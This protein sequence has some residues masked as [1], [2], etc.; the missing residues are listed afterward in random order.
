MNKVLYKNILL[1]ILVLSDF[2]AGAISYIFSFNIENYY[3]YESN[4]YI[5]SLLIILLVQSAWSTIFFFANLYNTRATLSRFDEIIR[6][7]PIIYSVLFI[8]IAFN[9]FAVINFHSDYKNILRYGLVFSTVLIINRFII[10]SV[11]KYFLKMKIGLNNALILGV[12][13]R[14]SDVFNSLQHSSY[15]VQLGLWLKSRL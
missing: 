10:H 12:N 2:L 11:Q 15:H 9:V 7:V 8:Y 3:A 14:G 13:R 4:S 6:L 5:N 1:F